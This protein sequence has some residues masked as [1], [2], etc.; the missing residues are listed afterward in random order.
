RHARVH[1]DDDDVAVV[2]VDG[3]LDVGAARV[4]ADLADDG[5]GVVAQAL[6]LLVGQRLRGSDGDAV[7]C[8][9]AHGVEVLDRADDNDGVVGVAH[10]LEL[11]LFPTQYRLFDE[12]RVHGRVVQALSNYAPE[13]SLV[14]SDAAAGAAQCEAGPD[15]GRVA[16]AANEVKAVCQC[17]DHL[18]RRCLDADA[19]HRLLEQLPV[20]ALLDGCVVGADQFNTVLLQYPELMQLRSQVESRLASQGREKRVGTLCHDHL[21]DELGGQRLDVGA[22]GYLRVGHYGRWVRVDEDYFEAGT[23]QRL[24][25]LRSRVVELGCLPDDD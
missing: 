3:E 11:V 5:D 12:D 16:D 18:A 25:G 21:F 6:V 7:T 8:V 17:R 15:D 24:T 10:H 23:A 19:R 2:G 14:V 4:D 1:L 20:L 9:Y 22:V 13:V